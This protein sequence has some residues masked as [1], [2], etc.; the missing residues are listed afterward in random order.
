MIRLGTSAFF[1][2]KPA[3][4]CAA[5]LFLGTLVGPNTSQLNAIQFGSERGDESDL[6]IAFVDP[7]KP[8]KYISR[9]DL[10]EM[11][12]K[13]EG[14]LVPYIDSYIPS[15]T[16]PLTAVVAAAGG[17]PTDSVT[18]ESYDGY[19]SIF[20]PEFIKEY[21]P[22]IMLDIIETEPGVLQIGKSPNLG[23]YYITYAKELKQGSPEILDPDNKRPYGVNKITIGPYETIFEKLYSGPLA[24]LEKDLAAGRTIFINNCMSCHAWE[25]DGLGGRFSNRVVPILSMHAQFNA[26]YFKEYVY[27][28]TKFQPDVLMPKHPHYEDETIQS[29]INFLKAVPTG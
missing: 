15:L 11:G 1:C 3:P 19:F 6:E 28:P 9:A 13:E 16:I 27:D 26:Q 21:A 18:A 20:Q 22:Y 17:Q 12:A 29:I 23:P 10:I 24:T 25:P 7:S 5:M 14:V 2:T 4:L 8:S